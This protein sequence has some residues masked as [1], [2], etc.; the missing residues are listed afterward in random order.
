ME[1]LQLTD[2]VSEKGPAIFF[3]MCALAIQVL[4]NERNCYTDVP[5]FYAFVPT[6]FANLLGRF[7]TSNV[8][9]SGCLLE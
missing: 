4:F 9:R 5:P 8:W 2:T 6:L 3:G 7:L 1:V